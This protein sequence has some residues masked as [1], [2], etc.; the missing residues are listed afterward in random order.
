MT[1]ENR[2][3]VGVDQSIDQITK[4]HGKKIDVQNGSMLR[5]Q[6]RT[7]YIVLNIQYYEKFPRFKS[8]C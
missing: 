8:A 5:L 3:E 1:D 7:N 4:P 2:R 6:S